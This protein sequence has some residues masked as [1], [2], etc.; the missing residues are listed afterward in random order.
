[1]IDAITFALLGLAIG[2]VYNLMAQGIVLM[3]QGSGVVN[4]AQGAFAMVGAYVF[5]E[6]HKVHSWSWVPAAL[7]AVA[8]TSALAAVAYLIVLGPLQKRARLVRMI[9]TLGLLI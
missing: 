5:L 6:L 1:M 7:I 4:F 3:Y 2:A 9:A 8:V